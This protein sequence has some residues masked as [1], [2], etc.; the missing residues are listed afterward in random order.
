MKI[1]MKYLKETKSCYVFS[2][3]EPY[4]ED[5]IALYLKKK[6]VD[7]AGID[8][9]NGITVTVEEGGAEA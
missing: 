3:G 2:A 6:Q 5:H 7:A 8:P 4:T 9:Q 1:K